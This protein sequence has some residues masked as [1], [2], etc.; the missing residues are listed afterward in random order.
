VTHNYS[1]LGVMPSGY[2]RTIKRRAQ[3]ELMELHGRGALRVPVGR[4]VPF[5]AL[6]E[7][8]E[9]LA[10]GEILGKAVLDVGGG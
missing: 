4:V 10:R 3:E 8:L 7:G 9:A 5:G 2:D 1:V 6:P